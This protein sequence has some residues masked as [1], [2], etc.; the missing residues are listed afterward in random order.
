[1]KV[2][3]KEK[4]IN[5]ESER[6]VALD[7]DIFQR[8]MNFDWSKIARYQ[9]QISDALKKYNQL[10]IRWKLLHQPD[11]NSSQGNNTTFY[12]PTHQFSSNRLSQFQTKSI[13]AKRFCQQPYHSHRWSLTL[14]TSPPT[15]VSREP[16]PEM[17]K[18]TL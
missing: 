5:E 10:A 9:T 7:I 11:I 3:N 6:I 12:Y 14:K 4:R 17:L 2:R 18:T 13:D 8:R 1:M 15:F 16:S